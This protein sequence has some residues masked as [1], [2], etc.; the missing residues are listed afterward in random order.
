MRYNKEKALVRGKKK[1]KAFVRIFGG[2]FVL[3]GIIL[4]TVCIFIYT[5]GTHSKQKLHLCRQLSW[6]CVGQITNRWAHRWWNTQSA[7][8]PIL[9]R[10]IC[11]HRPCI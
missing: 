1:D 9:P 10:S 4:F 3:V 2:I 8:R 7:E 6:P 5:S 11:L